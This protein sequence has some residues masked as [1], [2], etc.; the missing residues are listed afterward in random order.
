MSQLIQI[1]KECLSQVAASLSKTPW[2]REIKTK[3]SGMKMA[4]KKPC[5]IAVCGEARSGKSTLINTFLDADLAKTGITET[6]ATLTFFRYGS[7]KKDG[8]V[9][10]HWTNGKETTEKIA[11]VHSMQ[12]YKEV[13]MKKAATISHI[14]I[15]INN[16]HLKNVTLVDTPGSGSLVS[17]HKRNTKVLT[18]HNLSD[19]LDLTGKAD[20]IIYLLGHVGKILD[21][22]FINNFIILNRSIV[23]PMN[24]IGVISKI[25]RSANILKNRWNFARDVLSKFPELNTVIPISALLEKTVKRLEVSGEL[26]DLRE[27]LSRIPKETLE[28]LLEEREFFDDDETLDDCPYTPAQRRKKRSGIQWTIFQMIARTL[29]SYDYNKALSLLR[30]YAGF[31]EL[32]KVLKTHFFERGQLLKCNH[33]ISQIHKELMQIYLYKLYIEKKKVMRR[34]AKINKFNML[35]KDLG[36]S[37]K[38]PGEMVELIKKTKKSDFNGQE[39]KS[40]ISS[41]LNQVEAVLDELAACNNDFSA[42]QLLNDNR[43]DFTGEEL[44]E[45]T[46]LFGQYGL[47]PKERLDH[48]STLDPNIIAQR[49]FYWQAREK[50]ARRTKRIV[51]EQAVSRYARILRVTLEDLDPEIQLSSPLVSM[52]TN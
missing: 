1:S 52:A 50:V 32:C 47:D 13:V 49:Q 27:W 26:S 14:E 38:M 46:N 21:S 35:V 24:M 18:H 25:D 2:E 42:L 7:D 45:L 17:V 8:T 9:I 15:F 44:S 41:A 22:E 20:A 10:C 30:E 43:C 23:H 39:V 34:K 40:K 51:A 6:T 37:F 28:E 29:M 48:L 16:P 33:I 11:F 4:L 31:E 5:L 12:G 19:S 3:V 36:A